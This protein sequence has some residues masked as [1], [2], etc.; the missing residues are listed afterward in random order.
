[1]IGGG[2]MQD[3]NGFVVSGNFHTAQKYGL[4]RGQDFEYAGFT[5]AV[6]IKSIKKILD[7][8]EIVLLTT[9]GSSRMGDLV[10]VNGYHLAATAA[11][12]LKAY[13][14]IY[15]AGQTHV[16]TLMKS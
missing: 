13:K 14:L 10:N 8:E 16:C 15:F 12:S 2:L 9:V 5:S 7:D 4:I 3:S 11:S 6:N 1:M